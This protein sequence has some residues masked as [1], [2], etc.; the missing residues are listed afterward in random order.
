MNASVFKRFREW[1]LS[2]SILL[3]GIPGWGYWLFAMA[4]IGFL[5]L[6]IG[7]SLESG[8][9]N[10][11]DVRIIQW[12]NTHT[13][14]RGSAELLTRL[15]DGG[16]VKKLCWFSAALLLVLR[17]WHYVPALFIVV[18]GE[19]ELNT[20]LQNLVARPRPEFSSVS[21]FG[22]PSGHTGAATALYGFW[23]LVVLSEWRHSLLRFYAIII[24]AVMTLTVAA[25]R[26]IL[27]AH[28]LTDVIGG[29]CFAIGWTLLWFWIS[30]NLWNEHC[31]STGCT[32]KAGVQKA[33]L[34]RRN[35]L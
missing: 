33:A 7:V 17:R 20:L 27:Q 30:L 3:H 4:Y 26:V 28:W 12:A 35:S 15:G 21:T 23:M 6:A 32:V 11:V 1:F 2:W 13:E 14:F 8:H 31:R 5:S 29:I 24:P 16:L 9:P 34:V 22:F 10:S 25:T 19:M 18:F